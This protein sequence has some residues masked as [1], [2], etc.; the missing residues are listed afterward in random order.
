MTYEWLVFVTGWLGTQQ[1]SGD[2]LC[3]YDKVHFFGSKSNLNKNVSGI[4]VGNGD[5]PAV[6]ESFCLSSIK[7]PFS[8]AYTFVFKR[9]PLFIPRRKVR[10]AYQ[11]SWNQRCQYI[12][13]CV[14][15][16]DQKSRVSFIHILVIFLPL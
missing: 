9:N 6:S 12:F 2:L 4:T 11:N 3:G 1:L 8:N 15:F 5:M 7:K 16:K 14:Q 13:C 10:M